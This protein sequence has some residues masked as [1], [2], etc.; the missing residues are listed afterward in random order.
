MYS[1]AQNTTSKI[2]TLTHSQINAYF[3]KNS[4]DFVVRE[5]PL[6]DFSGSGEHLILNI[7]KKGI[8]THE[9]L[10]I[11]SEYLGIKMRDFGYAGLK[12]KQGLTTQYISI[13]KKFENNISNFTHNNLQIK[14]SFLHNNK[15][16]IGHLK[17]NKFFIRLKKVSKIDAKKL[18]NALK[19]LDHQGFAN[20]FG[21]QRFGK[22][23]DNF[24][25]GFKILKEDKKLK[26]PKIN[27]F[28]LSAFQSQLFNNYLSK[29][30]EL[31]HL[32]NEFSKDEL[33]KIY[34]ITKD[35]A[36][37][38]KDQRQFFKL[39]HNEALGHYP[40][41]K[42]FI[43]KDLSSE[44]NR[45]NDRV[46]SPLGLLLGQKAFKVEEGLAQRLENEIFVEFLPYLSKLQGARR[47]L[48][49]Y[50]EDLKFHYNEEKA[51]FGI[52]FFLQKGSYATI[53]LE[54][55]FQQHLVAPPL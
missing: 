12:D 51:H 41:G 54:E 28:L 26:N 5:V 21:Y 4:E 18:E 16:K 53:I 34:N 19:I 46:I 22:F 45:F 7:T 29:R 1:Q 39:L 32:A 10:Q 11:L 43:C 13:P 2:L 38:I 23:E 40:Y 31:S 37:Y 14:E 44:I 33:S 35:E 24:I 42:C 30:V 50:L 36:K 47:Y 3:S 9:A 17:G 15:L 8:S 52:E 20:Y 55:L 49:S 6:Y 48:W 25:Q 27:N